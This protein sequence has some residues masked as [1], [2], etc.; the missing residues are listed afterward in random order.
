MENSVTAGFRLSAQQERVWAQQGVEAPAWAAVCT[1]LIE[2]PLQPSRLQEALRRL[3]ARHEILRTLFHRQPGLKL[4][5][6]VIRDSVEPAYN[7]V[8]LSSRSASEQKNELELLMRGAH[9]AAFDLEAGPT[10]KVLVAELAADRHALVLS[11]PALCADT[12]S[13]HILASE[14][15]R[16][17]AGDTPADDA[18]QYADIVEW[19][20]ELLEGEDTRAGRDFWRDYFRHLDLS[21]AGS[22]ALPFETKPGAAAFTPEL[23]E[24]SPDA[25]TARQVETACRAQNATLQDWLLTCWFVLLSRLTGREAITV[26]CGFDGR[27]YQELEDALGIFAKFLPLRSSIAADARFDTLLREVK[28]SVSEANKW[29]ESFAWSKVEGLTDPNNLAI[30][31]GF[32]CHQGP[33][34]QSAGEV[35]FHLEHASVHLER[36]QLKLVVVQGEERGL[37]LEFHY[38]ASRFERASVERIAGYF[39]TLLAAAVQSPETPVSRLPLLSQRERRQL[40]V[41][42]NQTAAA[43]PQDRCLHQLFEAQAARTPERSALVFDSQQLSYRQWNQQ[44]NQLAHYL[45]TLGVGPDSLVGLCLDRSAQMMVA[46][47]AILKA[48]GAYVPL[49][50][51]NPKPRLAQQL[52]GAAALIT[53][54]KLLAQMPEFSGHT[55]CLGRDDSGWA[56]QPVTDPDT[57]LRPRTWSM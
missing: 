44:A 29:Q 27:K 48:G 57:A 19:Q 52:A 30:P 2:G 36:Y 33:Q 41:D 5:F 50:P 22:L 53:E 31:L 47:L 39:Q 16:E 38:D 54:P 4:P 46:L 56:Q 24:V 1:V 12:R 45:R 11:V 25:T 13:L 9:Q 17:Y 34:K 23:C 40:L 32:E 51:D 20:N 21:A 26:G 10:L 55:L 6:Q 3:T 28:E 37:S 18:M 8:S 49:N 14:L 7:T 35:S 42:C 43:Y 15:S